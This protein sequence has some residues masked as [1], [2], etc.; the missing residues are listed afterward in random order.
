M[1]ENWLLP[2]DYTVG[3]VSV[4]YGLMVGIGGGVPSKEV[5]I[6]LD[7]VVVSKPTGT[8]SGVVQY[9]YSKAIKGGHF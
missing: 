4:H 1:P 7:D 6:R 3:W 9:D 2:E 8:I 5:D